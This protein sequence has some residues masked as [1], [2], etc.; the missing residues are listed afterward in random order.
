MIT[1]D[2]LKHIDVVVQF[3]L[4]H[5][6]ALM[7]D[8]IISMIFDGMTN[9]SAMNLGINMHGPQSVGKFISCIEA[10]QSRVK[11]ARHYMEKGDGITTM[12]LR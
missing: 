12:V 5:E 10:L 8:L 3:E 6:E 9:E 4:S 2:D 1:S 11:Q 7:L